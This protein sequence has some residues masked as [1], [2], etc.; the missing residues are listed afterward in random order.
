MD[1]VDQP[2]ADKQ[3]EVGAFEAHPLAVLGC[4]AEFLVEA[5]DRRRVHDFPLALGAVSRRT[6]SRMPRR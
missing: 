1:D 4:A 5:D 2:E 3:V 6:A